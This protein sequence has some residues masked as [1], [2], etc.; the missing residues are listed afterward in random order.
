[1]GAPAPSAQAADHLDPLH[2]RG[3]QIEN[4]QRRRVAGGGGECAPPARHRGGLVAVPPEAEPEHP[5]DLRV[6]V[7]DRGSGRSPQCPRHLFRL[8]FAPSSSARARST[9]SSPRRRGQRCMASSPGQIHRP[10]RRAPGT[11]RGPGSGGLPAHAPSARAG[12]AGLRPQ[13]AGHA[14]SRPPRRGTGRAHRVPRAPGTAARRER[15]PGHIDGLTEPFAGGPGPDLPEVGRGLTAVGE[16]AAGRRPGM[17]GHE[18]GALPARKIFRIAR[19]GMLPGDALAPTMTRRTPAT[20]ALLPTGVR[21]CPTPRRRQAIAALTGPMQ[22]GRASI[23]RPCA[24][25]AGRQF[26]PGPFMVI[27]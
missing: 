23:R 21:T 22:P 11:A 9:A 13:P 26:P 27:T 19:A 7:D 12:P 4:H 18:Q 24:L 2:V 17:N 14:R 10:E 16:F 15:P 1:M 6:G 20:A 8:G 3:I 25:I 5:H